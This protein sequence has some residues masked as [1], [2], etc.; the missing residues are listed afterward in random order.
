M[1]DRF[2]TPIKIAR[3]E[4]IPLR[5][6][7]GAPKEFAAV[8][9]AW[10][11]LDIALVRIETTE[12]AVG[13]GDGFAYMCLEPVTRAIATMVAPRLVGQS[14]ASPAAANDMLQRQLHLFGRYG[15]TMFAISAVDVALWDL[16]GKITGKSLARL[17]ADAPAPTIDAYASL[18]RYGERVTGPVEASC[19]QG[20][21]TIKLHEIDLA[22]CRRARAAMDGRALMND[23]NCPWTVAQAIDWARAGRD[24]DLAW[25]EEPVYPP[26]DFAGLA[27]VQA[28]GGIAVAT[29]ENACTRWQFDQAIAR[30][31]AFIQPSMSKLGGLSEFVAVAEAT[32]QAGLK[33]A[34]HSPYFGPGLL[35][36]MHA[37]AALSPSS[38][39][40]CL[41]G[42]RE[43]CLY[44]DAILP[45]DGKVKVPTAP[46]LGLDPDPAVV[47]RYRQ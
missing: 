8:A 10:T 12:G 18:L 36:T 9:G 44:G 46:G 30:R 16:L 42:D 2:P 14:I 27:R 41:I 28:E 17:L 4:A 43:A 1:I 47:S 29:G 26:E 20:Y 11:M 24:L 5:I 6:P 35:A 22:A 19:A 21:A 13:W 3:V 45:R 25:L 34:P 33:L 7:F 23:P 40:E 39:L 37:L 32:K 31:L 38:P 15:I